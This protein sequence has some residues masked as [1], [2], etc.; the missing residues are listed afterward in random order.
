[1]QYFEKTLTTQVN[2]DIPINGINQDCLKFIPKTKHKK[3][4]KIVIGDVQG[5]IYLIKNSKQQW[6]SNIWQKVDENLP[7]EEKSIKSLQICKILKSKK[8]KRDRILFSDGKYIK[9]VNK[10]NLL[11]SDNQ[12]LDN[13]YGKLNKVFGDEDNL[14]IHTQQNNTLY[15]IKFKKSS[16]WLSLSYDLKLQTLQQKP[17]LNEI[18]DL[19]YDYETQN[20]VFSSLNCVFITD[21]DLNAVTGIGHSCDLGRVKVFDIRKQRFNAFSIQPFNNQQEQGN[22]NQLPLI[23][24]QS[25]LVESKKTQELVLG[26]YFKNQY[27]Q[28]DQILSTTEQL[29]CFGYGDIFKSEKNQIICGY[30]GGFQIFQED[31]NRAYQSIESVTQNILLPNTP[32]SCESGDFKDDLI[33]QNLGEFIFYSQDGQLTSISPS[34]DHNQKQDFNESQ[35][36]GFRFRQETQNSNPTNQNNRNFIDLS[37]QV[38][39]QNQQRQVRSTSLQPSSMSLEESQNNQKQNELIQERSSSQQKSKNDVSTN[40]ILQNEPSQNQIPPKPKQKHKL[41]FRVNR[42]SNQNLSQSGQKEGMNEQATQKNEQQKQISF[43]QQIYNDEIEQTENKQQQQ[44]ENHKKQ[45]NDSYQYFI[46][47]LKPK[48]QSKIVDEEMDEIEKQFQAALNK[49]SQPFIVSKASSNFS[50]NKCSKLSSVVFSTNSNNKTLGFKQNSIKSSINNEQRQELVEKIMLNTQNNKYY[51]AEDILKITEKS[52]IKQQKNLSKDSTPLKQDCNIQDFNKLQEYQQQQQQQQSQQQQSPTKLDSYRGR[53]RRPSLNKQRESS[54]NFQDLSCNFINDF[55]NQSNINYFDQDISLKQDSQSKVESNGYIQSP[56]KFKVFQEQQKSNQKSNIV[57]N[58][59]K[60]LQKNQINF[61]FNNPLE[62]L[63][64]SSNDNSSAFNQQKQQKLKEEQEQRGQQQMIY[65]RRRISSDFYN[66]SQEQSDQLN[67]QSILHLNQQNEKKDQQFQK[68]I[69]QSQKDKIYQKSSN[70]TS[71]LRYSRQSSIDNFYNQEK[72]EERPKILINNNRNNN[73]LSIYTRLEEVQNGDFGSTLQKFSLNKD[74]SKEDLISNTGLSFQQSSEDLS[75]KQNPIKQNS[76]FQQNNIPKYQYPVNLSQKNQNKKKDSFDFFEDA[77]SYLNI[78]N[79]ANQS[80]KNQ[81]QQNEN[82]KIQNVNKKEAQLQNENYNQQ[83]DLNAKN[84]NNNLNNLSTSYR[85]Q[86]YNESKST[87]LFLNGED[88]FDIYDYNVNDKQNES[89]Q[90][91]KKATTQ[92]NNSNN[93]EKQQ[94]QNSQQMR[95]Q[96]P[97]DNRRGSVKQT[98]DLNEQNNHFNENNNKNQYFQSNISS[99]HNQRNSIQN[100]FNNNSNKQAFNQQTNTKRYV[101]DSPTKVDDEQDEYVQDNQNYQHKNLLWRQQ[102]PS[103]QFLSIYQQD[104]STMHLLPKNKTKAFLYDPDEIYQLQILPTGYVYE[105]QQQ[106]QQSKYK[107]TS[108]KIIKKYN[109]SLIELFKDQNIFQIEDQN[110]LTRFKQAQKQLKYNHLQNS[111]D[112]SNENDCIEL[113]IENLRKEIQD[114]QN[115]LQ[116]ICQFFNEQVTENVKLL[117][118]VNYKKEVIYKQNRVRYNI[119]T[120]YQIQSIYAQIKTPRSVE[121]TQPLNIDINQEENNEICIVTEQFPQLQI[122]K[123]QGA[124]EEYKLQSFEIKI[125]DKEAKSIYFDMLYHEDGFTVETAFLI[126]F[127]S[128][129]N[130]CYELVDKNKAF[131][132]LQLKNISTQNLIQDSISNYHSLKLEGLQKKQFTSLFKSLFNFQINEYMQKYEEFFVKTVNT[133]FNF[134]IILHC[135]ENKFIFYSQSLQY[136]KCLQNRISSRIDESVYKIQFSINTSQK[137]YQ[138][139]FD[140]IFSKVKFRKDIRE[141]QSIIMPLQEIIQTQGYEGLSKQ[142]RRLLQKQDELNKNFL[143]SYD[144]DEICRLQLDNIVRCYIQINP[145]QKSTFEQQKTVIDNLIFNLRVKQIYSLLFPLEN[146]SFVS[147]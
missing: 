51:D 13:Q 92:L 108:F 14:I 22:Q 9:C 68:E 136:I 38:I 106:I 36:Q 71:P 109:T 3:K 21:K 60:E 39:N 47:Q 123:C 31:L 100:F 73:D 127:N 32:I 57:Q 50:D 48:K 132:F 144:F 88:E 6:C 40:S 137:A 70:R 23:P 85:N 27:A 1:M 77:N 128:F 25:V 98:S 97:K 43:Q 126:K 83:Y 81:D 52:P 104:E 34:I 90:S 53:L 102:I 28:I 105:K 41:E 37:S 12:N 29:T 139:H 59:E 64:K 101:L 140:Q 147:N 69:E 113:I 142:Y 133:I 11:Q 49:T 138:Y 75:Y 80:E 30:K 15:K 56:E 42:N 125:I 107:N 112:L 72:Q 7:E 8:N 35:M 96:I 93:F 24:I 122:N 120:E 87:K 86:S 111:F 121:I 95:Q 91:L 130:S 63:K 74:Y 54:F 115:E 116:E 129:E 135:L 114:I 145:K 55:Q 46:S 66:L 67:N 16:S 99:Y 131:Q 2:L 5:F 76:L 78:S 134:N 26:T 79:Q 65:R 124:N 58:L 94:K 117:P 119:Q 45:E 89:I 103:R 118:S 17:Y 19:D 18:N 82:S 4:Q 61:N 141:Q 146:A 84:N 33:H 44:E 110:S 62:F 10:G 143:Q 20:L